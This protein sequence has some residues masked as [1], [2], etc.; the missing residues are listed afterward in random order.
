[1]APSD[2]KALAMIG[3]GSMGGGMA[4]LFAEQGVHVSLQDPSADRM[5]ALLDSAKKDG[6]QDKLSKHDD[7]KSLCKSLESYSGSGAP[8]VFV[9]SLPH[10]SIGDTVLTGLMPLLRKGDCIVDCGNEHWEN[11]ERRMGMC[12]VKGIRYVGCGVSGGYQAARRGP[13]MCPGG[14]D[15]SLFFVLPLLEQV[16]ATAPDNSPCVARIGTGGAGHYCKMIH[17]GI[18]HGMMSAISE[19]WALMARGM[20]M[21]LDD[22]GDEFQRWNDNGELH[23]TFLVSIGADICRKKNDKG[24]KVLPEVED[25]VVQDYT[26]E[27]GTGVWSNDEAIEQHVPAPTLTAAH[28]LRIASGDLAQ[29]RAIYDTL[30]KAHPPQKLSIQDQKAFLEDLRQAVYAASLAAYAQGLII[31]DRANKSKNFNI[32]YPNLLQI[33][34]AGCIIRSDY[35]NRELLLPI[36]KQGPFVNPL[37]DPTFASELKKMYPALKRVVMKAMEADQVVPSLSAS[38]EYLK[39]MT[40]TELP[41]SFY[42]AELD[43]F[44]AHNYDRKGEDPEGKPE[45]G[46]QHFEWKPA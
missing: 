34:R 41:T 1:M 44:G 15:D 27:E 19:A 3:C 46:R 4:L 36:Y 25:K 39:Y 24:N 30:G 16:A 10:G 5:N 28:Y 38:L 9:W 11:S 26:G 45:T 14:D 2:I 21:S 12:Y 23:N 37:T 35:I 43:Y 33:W 7:Y 13:S 22:V 42:E 40:S 20:D 31:I 6:L 17:N 8:R 18:E 32:N 29:R